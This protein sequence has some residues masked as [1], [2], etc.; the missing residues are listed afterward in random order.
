MV[1]DNLSFLIL[2]SRETLGDVMFRAHFSN[3]LHLQHYGVENTKRLMAVLNS[4]V[5]ALQV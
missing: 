4:L 2:R 3:D 1:T 5:F